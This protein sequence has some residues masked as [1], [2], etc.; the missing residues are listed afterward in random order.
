MFKSNY[1]YLCID[2]IHNEENKGY[3]TK[4]KR[5]L[6][7]CYHN[8]HGHKRSE[9]C[10]E[11]CGDIYLIDNKKQEYNV[12]SYGTMYYLYHFKVKIP[13]FYNYIYNKTKGILYK[14]FIGEYKLLNSNQIIQCSTDNKHWL[15]LSGDHT[16][17]S[18][19]KYHGKYYKYFRTIK[20]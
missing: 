13:K 12:Y 6:A 3:F 18:L 7:T 2:S 14:D 5:Y 4:G 16:L 1:K 17:N 8:H 20:D 15:S 9:V 11:T 19:N 10:Y